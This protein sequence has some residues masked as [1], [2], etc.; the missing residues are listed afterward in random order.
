MVANTDQTARASS[1]CS[2]AIFLVQHGNRKIEQKQALFNALR[3]FTDKTSV[4]T[5]I[6]YTDTVYPG[7]S[8][9]RCAGCGGCIDDGGCCHGGTDHWAQIPGACGKKI[10]KTMN[11]FDQM[12]TL[13]HLCSATMK[14]IRQSNGNDQEAINKV[15]KALQ[16]FKDAQ[17]V[18]LEHT[19]RE[20]RYPGYFGNRCSGCGGCID[21]GGICPCGWDHDRQVKV[22]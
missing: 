7:R 15:I 18:K 8:G 16:A 22:N 19:T 6:E 17:S 2:T 13:T 21:E 20:P 1:L 4:P 3:E 12:E 5:K 9:N 14:K 11:I 10:T